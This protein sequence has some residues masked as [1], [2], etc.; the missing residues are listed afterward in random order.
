[1]F[2]FIC[3]ITSVCILSGNKGN[4]TLVYKSGNIT[5][6]Y[7]HTRWIIEKNNIIS[8]GFGI[9][10]EIPKGWVGLIFP[11]SSVYKKNLDLTNCVGVIDSDYRGEIS[12]KFR[13]LNPNA[14]NIYVVGERAAQIVF[15][16]H[17][18]V[19]FKVSNELSETLRGA[20]GYGHTGD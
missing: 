5:C 15:V 7:K 17:G 4:T 8:Y 16:Q 12:A 1:M 11:R 14:D 3:S 2:Q 20:G 6:I 10:L 13:L 18:N 9:A 19:D